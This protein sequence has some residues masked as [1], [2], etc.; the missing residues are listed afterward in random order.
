MIRK[1]DPSDVEALEKSVN[2]SATRVST[3]WISYLI[4]GLYLTISVGGVTHRQLLLEEATTL[5]V[6]NINLPLWRFYVLAPI[7]FVLIH[8]YVLLQVLLLAR[9]T[10]AYNRAV[11]RAEVTSEGDSSLRQ[12]LANTLFAQLFAGSTRERQGLVGDALKLI[13]LL[14]LAICPVLVL[15]AFQFKFLPYHS[16]FATWT[17]RL[18]ILIDLTVVILM[19]PI[20]FDPKRDMDWRRS[21]RQPPLI[22]CV[23]FF[24][25][26]VSLGIA[27][28]PGEPH[29]NVF[30]GNPIMK[31]Q[32]ER[33]ALFAYFD[34]LDVPNVIVVDPERLTKIEAA[35]NARQ[36]RASAREPMRDFRYRNLS[37][38]NFEDA[39]MRAVDFRGATLTGAILSGAQL[40]G[41]NFEKADLEHA[42]LL[43]A[44]AED[45]SFSEAALNLAQLNSAN[46][47]NSLMFQVQL[48]GARLQKTRMQGANLRYA[49]LQAADLLG[50]ELQ[51]ADLTGAK[52]Q[53]ASLEA[54]QFQGADLTNAELGGADLERTQLQGTSLLRA[55]L[56]YSLID[57]A[58]VWQ[59]KGAICRDAYVTRTYLKIV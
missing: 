37:C 28:F 25:L 20:V 46:M 2:D 1:I 15:L 40:K 24:I 49:N 59:A 19:W 36:L 56:T 11:E 16:H 10:E 4:F 53:A 45:A 48:Q 8:F 51:G 27:N 21:L 35:A 57:H 34:R 47:P 26:F 23:M 50:A 6:L 33:W 3:I 14:T 42:A 41:A 43:D 31:A 7:F 39:D 5:P 29:L 13:A 17:H 9:T 38:G 44:S 52:L 32:C 18:L 12:R 22:A 55:V 54:T 58:F 30:T